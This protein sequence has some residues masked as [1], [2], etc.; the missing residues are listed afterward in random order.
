MVP[1][2]ATILFLTAAFSLVIFRQAF[3]FR[4]MLKYNSEEVFEPTGSELNIPGEGVNVSIVVPFRNEETTLPALIG[5]IIG[6]TCPGD[7]AGQ[8]CQENPA[9]QTCPGELFEVI[10]VNDH[11][12]DGSKRLA[13]LAVKGMP[14]FRVLDLPDGMHGKK[15]ALGYGINRAAGRWI[16]QI[17]ADCRLRPEFLSVRMEHLARNPS[18]LSAGFVSVGGHRRSF[19]EVF[20]RLD[21]LSLAAV[22]AGSFFRGRPMMCSGANLLYSRELYNATRQF[23]PDDR[24]S[25]G[26]DMF[27]MIGARK[28]GRSVTFCPDVETVVETTPSEGLA[29]LIRQRIRW[30]SKTPRYGMPD[31]QAVALLVALTNLAMLLLPLWLIL[32]PAAWPWLA[33]A[34]VLKTTADFHLLWLATGFTH[35]RKDLVYFLPVT[36]FYYPFQMVVIAGILLRKPIWKGRSSAWMHFRVFAGKPA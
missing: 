23:D 36:L 4:R 2:T 8:T 27:L 30:A 5:D 25:S 21:V 18:D 28:S 15:A 3:G 32:F 34:G 7:P 6:Q 12:T 35:R 11:S 13:E 33:G 14:L 10:L 26:D 22:G 19:T 9:G 1:F 16:L 24:V 29:A 20:E 31:I 17:D